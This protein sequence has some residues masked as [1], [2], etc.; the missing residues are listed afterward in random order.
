[1]QGIAL[2]PIGQEVFSLVM[3]SSSW[4]LR[5]SLNASTAFLFVNQNILSMVMVQMPLLINN[6]KSSFHSWI[7]IQL[8]AYF[9]ERG[10]SQET[11]QR[12][13]VMQKYGDQVFL[14]L[15]IALLSFLIRT[16]VIPPVPGV[17]VLILNLHPSSFK[18]KISPIVSLNFLFRFLGGRYVFHICQ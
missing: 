7:M 18:P 13:G 10:I 3:F 6:D 16:I 4:N 8:I 17:N 2:E 12:N 9:A 14:M 11:L 5:C 1:M 15:S